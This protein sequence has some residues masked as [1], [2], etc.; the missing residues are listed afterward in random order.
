[1]IVTKSSHFERGN[2]AIV[3]VKDYPW[4]A[5]RIKEVPKN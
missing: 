2:F 4:C 5:C 1:M 3:K